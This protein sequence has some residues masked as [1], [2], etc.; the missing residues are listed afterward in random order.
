[1]S[2]EDIKKM[3]G[4]QYPRALECASVMHGGNVEAWVGDIIL[5][6]TDPGAFRSRLQEI[7]TRGYSVNVEGRTLGVSG[8]AAPILIEDRCPSYA[9]SVS[10]P[11][12]RLTADRHAQLGEQVRRSADRI[13]VASRSS[14]A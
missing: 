11:S 1:M 4:D 10:G 13:A 6:V 9:I 7:K 14:V 2:T 3:L 12:A 5:R 8:V